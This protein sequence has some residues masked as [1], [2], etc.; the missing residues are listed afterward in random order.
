MEAYIDSNV[1]IYAFTNHDE[2]GEGCRNLL[3]MVRE[4]KEK[5]VTSSLAFNEGFFVISRMRSFD[6]S[7]EF[8]KVLFETPN[9]RIA[10][11]GLSTVSLAFSLSRKYKL[12][13]ND[14]VHAA[15]AIESR[16]TIFYSHDKDLRRI[17]EINIKT[18]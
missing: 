1:F 17:A 16:C 15:A 6:E 13:P 5:A 11:V 7:I 8:A 3:R 18:P 9:L 12:K 14:A 4:G 2:F 10:N